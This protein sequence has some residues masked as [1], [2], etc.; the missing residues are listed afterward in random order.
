MKKHIIDFIKR[1]FIAMGFGPIILAIIYAILGATGVIESIAV[2]EVVLG[3]LSISLMA[4]IAAGVTVLYQIESL[5]L[6]FAILIHGI[7]LYLA[8]AIVYLVNGWL[9]EGA[10]PFLIFTVCFVVGYAVVWAIV[11]LCIRRST[12]KLNK[13]LTAK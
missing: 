5:P 11:Y 2:S 7:A 8:Y 4:F 3:V 6:I 1:G 9:A 13:K 12:D 10:L